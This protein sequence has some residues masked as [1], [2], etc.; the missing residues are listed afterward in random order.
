MYSSELQFHVSSPIPKYIPLICCCNRSYF[1]NC[2]GGDG[3]GG[4]D[5]GGGGGGVAGGDRSKRF[6]H[7]LCSDNVITQLPLLQFV[8][9]GS[10]RSNRY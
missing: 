7:L 4:G 10:K 5:G 9:S 1:W 3:V 6:V 8:M 2:G